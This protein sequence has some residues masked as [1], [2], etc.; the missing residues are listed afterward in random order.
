MKAKRILIIDDDRSMVDLI[1]AITMHQG[2]QPTT[3]YDIENGLFGF[4]KGLYDLVITDIFMKGVGGIEGINQIR[5]IDKDV[6]IIAVSGGYNN[7]SPEKT[8]LAAQ[9]I[10]ANFGLAKPFEPE[11]LIKVI[12]QALETGA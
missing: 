12:N 2:H 8:V 10:G 7:I 6:P 5:N 1:A 4:S 9:K 3:S 11:D